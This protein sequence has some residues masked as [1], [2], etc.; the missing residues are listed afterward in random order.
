MVDRKYDNEL[1]MP[2]DKSMNIGSQGQFPEVSAS[3][4]W[5]Q[6]TARFATTKST[7]SLLVEL[8][9]IWA[10]KATILKEKRSL[11]FKYKYTLKKMLQR[12]QSH[13]E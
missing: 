6:N 4:A 7:N 1:E 3:V 11:C 5:V 12:F 10:V 8:E 2:C 9:R 13:R